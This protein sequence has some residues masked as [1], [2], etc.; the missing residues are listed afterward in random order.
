M[1]ENLIYFLCRIPLHGQ[2][3]NYLHSLRTQIDSESCSA[4]LNLDYNCTFHNDMAPNGVPF[5]A[6]LTGKA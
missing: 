2:F 1:R 6:N 4:K 3:G 5:G